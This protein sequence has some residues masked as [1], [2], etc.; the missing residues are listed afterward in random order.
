MFEKIMNKNSEGFYDLEI[1]ILVGPQ[2]RKLTQDWTFEVTLNRCKKQA[3]GY[4]KMATVN[5][6]CNNKME[7]FGDIP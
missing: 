2:I 4:F 6:L 7:K 5:F 1:D 3:W